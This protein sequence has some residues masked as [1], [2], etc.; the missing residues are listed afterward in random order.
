VSH[1]G[2]YAPADPPPDAISVSTAAT[3]LRVNRATIWRWAVAIPGFGRQRDDGIWLIDPGVMGIVGAIRMASGNR[4]LPL[5]ALV[6]E[7]E[8]RTEL[9][10][11]V[12]HMVR[13]PD[14]VAQI[15]AIAARMQ[16]ASA[17]PPKP[18]R[19]DTPVQS[20]QVEDAP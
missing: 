6:A 13:H 16:K 8:R 3:L 19:P 14:A 15:T 5:G 12:L 2:R 18:K 4:K 7:T 20:I 11:G 1:P 9:M 10:R 17:Q